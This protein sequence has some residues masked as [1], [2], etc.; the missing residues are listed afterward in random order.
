MS[1]GALAA[2]LLALALAAALGALRC[3]AD[4][5]LASAAIYA[6]LGVAL[7]AAAGKA[8]LDAL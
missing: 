8:A 3:L 5:L 1:A 6:V 4:K 7:A 2:V